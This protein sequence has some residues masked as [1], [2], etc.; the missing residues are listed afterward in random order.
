MMS[1]GDVITS[2]SMSYD[3]VLS[4]AVKSTNIED[5]LCVG[6]M[7]ERGYNISVKGNQAKV[8]KALTCDLCS[9]VHPGLLGSLCRIKGGFETT[10]SD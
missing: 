3:S 2:Y 10:V 6:T 9:K 4:F 7:K 8:V 5:V 1:F